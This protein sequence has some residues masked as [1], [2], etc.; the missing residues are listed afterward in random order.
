[1]SLPDLDITERRQQVLRAVI[2]EHISSG[3]PIGSKTLVQNRGFET[4][5]STLRYELAWLESVGLLG[6]PHTSAGR[7]PTE[8]GYR[9]YAGT[10][11]A[12]RIAAQPF[13]VQ[14]T[15]ASREVDDALRVTTEAL[16]Q[17]TSLLAIASAP[18]VAEVDIRHI[19]ILS[20]QPQVVMML[21]ISGTGAVAKRVFAFD[22]PVD[23]GLVEWSREYLNETLTGGLIS[24]RTVRRR[25]ED[26]DLPVRE[27]DF[28][29]A[30]A[31]V[32]HELFEAGAD[33]L[34]V[35][36]ASRLMSELRAQNQQELTQLASVLEERAVMLGQLRA[37]LRGDSVT[38]RIGEEHEEAALRPVAPHPRRCLSDWS[39]SDGLRA[40]DRRRA[41][42]GGRAQ[43]VRRGRLRRVNWALLAAGLGLAAYQVW[44]ITV[45]VLGSRQLDP[46]ERKLMIITLIMTRGLGFLLGLLLIAGAVWR[47]LQ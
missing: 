39:G 41:R 5:A 20:L 2:E 42:C 45:R 6:H 24:E 38:V 29:D 18:S 8:L 12:E 44:A 36:G 27:R 23:T 19:E 31:P 21:V 34:V 32:F 22:G 10:L 3:Q 30:I 14:L 28:L 26:P 1:M 17:V 16:S 11:L 35:G 25:M 9:F 43:R 37:A 13:E 40:G 4:S 46:P 47:S 7:V 15:E 33:R